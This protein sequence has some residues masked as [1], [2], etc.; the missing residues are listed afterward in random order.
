MKA[1]VGDRI[2]V[3]GHRVNDPDRVARVLEVRGEEGG[4]P[5]VVEWRDSG[6]TSLFFPGSDAQVRPAEARS[7][8]REPEMSGG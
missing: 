5:Y 6:R 4:P 7:G 1:S 3:R 2:V 8:I